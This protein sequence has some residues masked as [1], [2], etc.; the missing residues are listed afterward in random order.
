MS[1]RYLSGETRSQAITQASALSASG[2]RLTFDLLGEEVEETSQADQ[3]LA[4]YEA[5]LQDLLAA[6]MEINLSIKPSQFGMGMNWAA[7]IERARQLG[8]NVANANGFLRWEMES[9]ETVDETLE[10]F[11]K[12]RET[13]GT[14]VGCVLQSMLRRTAQDAKSLIG[15]TQKL[16]V[17]LVKGV[18]IEPPEIAFQE[19]A[20]ITR[21]YIEVM[22]DLLRGGAFVGVATHDPAI[23]EA[24]RNLLKSH[25]EYL[26][27]CEVQM[28]LGVQER[29][30]METR[31]AGIPVRVYL[32]YG[33][34]WRAY[35]LRRL[36]QNPR[37]AG[38]AFQGM[39]GGR[40]RLKA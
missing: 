30:R 8:Q 1:Q 31:R 17:R 32:P 39:F 6:E 25:P 15:G 22:E 36:R 33:H 4:E 37:L 19:P 38:L 23:I 11:S 35:V 2:Y 29:L 21:N 18:Y 13:C 10:G 40:E 26:K 12:L 16:N 27:R 24:L 5:L 34:A 20:A 28:L 14:A 7:G 9:S 3:A